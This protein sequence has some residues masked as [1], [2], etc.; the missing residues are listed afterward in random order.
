MVSEVTSIS[1]ECSGNVLP[2]PI[3]VL[4]V[5]RMIKLFGWEDRVAKQIEEKREAELVVLKK[6]QLLSIVNANLK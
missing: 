5:T 2:F 1:P 3:K 6:R 4:S